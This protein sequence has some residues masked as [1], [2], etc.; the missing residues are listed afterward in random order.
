MQEEED[1]MLIIMKKNAAS[2]LVYKVQEEIMQQCICNLKD[3]S[4]SV[5][6]EFLKEI[7]EICKILW[8]QE[9]LG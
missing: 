1:K 8:G 2:L 6:Q 4:Y 3:N 5:R 7:V 9:S